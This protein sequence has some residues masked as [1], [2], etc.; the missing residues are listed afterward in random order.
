MRPSRRLTALV[1]LAVFPASSNLALAAEAAK[2][3]AGYTRATADANAGFEKISLRHAHAGKRA[4]LAVPAHRGTACRRHSRGEESRRLGERQAEGIR[5]RGRDGEVRRF[6]QPSEERV[7]QDGGASGRRAFADG[8]QHPPGQG[9][10]LTRPVPGLS[11]L[12]RLGQGQRPDHLRELRLPGRPRA[13]QVHGPL[14]GGQDRP[15]QVRRGLPRTQ[16]QGSAGS[17]RGRRPHLLGSGG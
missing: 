14:R 3:P 1:V 11:R 8:R 16:G 15:G 12:R 2:A 7:A 10:H 9:L 13:P 6:P 5:P 17:R 4:A